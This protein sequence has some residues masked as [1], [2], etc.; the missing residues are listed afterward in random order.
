MKKLTIALSLCCIS[1]VLLANSNEA[2]TKYGKVAELAT[3]EIKTVSFQKIAKSSTELVNLAK[4][5]L[6]AFTKSNPE[7]KVYLDAVMLA[8]DSM[9]QLSLDEIEADYHLDGKLPALT[10]GDCYHAKDLLVHPATVVV[11]AK[12]LK[13]TSKNRK[14]MSHEIEEVIQHLNLVKL[15]VK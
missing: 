4:D 7:C 2:L 8:S 6:P 13:D 12:T 15:A 14:K 5:I 3:T 1:T 9:Q 11:M 10:S